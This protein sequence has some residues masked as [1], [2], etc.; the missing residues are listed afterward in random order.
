MCELTSDFAKLKH[1]CQ[2]G[3]VS[4][5]TFYEIAHPLA[6]RRFE[7]LREYLIA[8]LESPNAIC[9]LNAVHLLGGHWPEK[10]DIGEKLINLLKYDPNDD[11]RMLSASALSH[12]KYAESREALHQCAN[13]PKQASFVKQS[14]ID[15]IRVLD[16]TPQVQILREQLNQIGDGD[17]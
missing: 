10:Q 8:L 9:R 12:I 14:C 7:P 3:Q 13:D 11:V 5:H 6:E 16:G 4:E 2:N 17:C 1:L 15:A